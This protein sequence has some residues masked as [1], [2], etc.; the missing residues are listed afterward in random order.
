SA[1]VIF[2]SPAAAS[3][4][5]HGL[6]NVCG[7]TAWFILDGNAVTAYRHSTFKN[8][9]TPLNPVQ[10]RAWLRRGV[11]LYTAPAD[12]ASVVIVIVDTGMIDVHTCIQNQRIIC[13]VV[14]DGVYLTSVCISM[15]LKAYETI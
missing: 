15:A 8:A 14:S 7:D 12:A 10:C 11:C 1:V 5:F 3:S 4:A 13:T 9:T 6:S 2:R